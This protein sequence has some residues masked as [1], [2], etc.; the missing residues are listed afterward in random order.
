MDQPLRKMR[1]LVPGFSDRRIDCEDV[2]VMG[3]YQN[4][5]LPHLVNWA[6]SHRDLKPYRDRVI[7]AAEG[8]ILEIGVG[9]GLIVSRPPARTH[10]SFESCHQGMG[11]RHRVLQ[12]S[13]QENRVHH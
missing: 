1:R 4:Q 6:M 8:R 3:F 12:P 13:E 5:I 2:L 7:S 10:S 9:S 11:I